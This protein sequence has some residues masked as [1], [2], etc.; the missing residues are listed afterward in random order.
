MERVRVMRKGRRDDAKGLK[1]C[2]DGVGPSVQRWLRYTPLLSP[3]TEKRGSCFIARRRLCIPCSRH[4]GSTSKE[5]TG[6]GA[7]RVSHVTDDRNLTRSSAVVYHY[8]HPASRRSVNTV[9]S[10]PSRHIKLLIIQSPILYTR[11]LL[12]HKFILLPFTTT[13]MRIPNQASKE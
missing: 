8:K 9:S 4:D 11:F 6:L 2:W 7:E 10:S 5:L 1:A 13:P 12:L 3:K